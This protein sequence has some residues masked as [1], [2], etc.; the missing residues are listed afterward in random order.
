L[1]DA[2]GNDVVAFTN[3]TL[4]VDT[5]APTLSSSTPADNATAVAIANNLVLTF[6]E[7]VQA[8]TGNIVITNAS[9]ATDTR[10]I[11]VTDA[12]VAFSGSTVTIN[13][14]ADLKAGANYNV[15][16]AATAVKDAAGNAYAGITNSTAL[17]FSTVAP[18]VS[19]LTLTTGV[20]TI[21]GTAADETVDGS[22]F[23]SGGVFVNTLGNADNI[24]GGG[25]TNTLFAQFF[26]AAG[27]ATVT[28]ASVKNIQTISVENTTT[29]GA[30]DTL[31]LANGDATVKTVKTANNVLA[32]TV[33]NI[34]SVPTSF[35]VSTTAVAFTGTI[36][37]ALLAGTTDATALILNNVTGAAA[38]AVGTVAAGSGY[39]TINLTSNGT[40]ASSITLDDGFATS[41]A[42][43]NIAGANNLT[44]TLTPTTVTK[45]DA[46]SYTGALTF[47]AAGAN[48]QNMTVTGGTGNDIISVNGYTTADIINGGLGTDRLTLINAEAVAATTVNTNVSGFE[49]IGLSDGSTGTITVSNFG[50]TGFRFGANTAGVT[51]VN[52]AAGTSSLDLQTFTGAGGALTT[53]IAGTATTD[54]MNVTQGS[55]AAGNVFGAALT[56]T[57]AET[58]NLLSQGGPNSYT[59]L[60]LTDTAAN[61]SLILTGS[62]SF[63]VIGATRADTI[64]ASGM[65]GT[66]VLTLTGG[67]GTTATTITGTANDDVLNGSTLGDIINGG[68][69]ADT[70]SNV[71]TGNT[72]TAADVL[73]GGVGFDTLILRGDSA[74]AAVLPATA[75]GVVANISGFTVGTSATTTDILSLSST[76]TNYAGAATGF[77]AGIAAATAVAAGAT[78]FQ[79]VAQN[80]AV[81]ALIAGTDLIKLTT[82]V[83]S[84]ATVQATFNAAIG[85]GTVTGL[86]IGTEALVSYYDTT[87]SRMVLLVVDAAL[88]TNTIIETG[89]AVTL[90]GTIDMS[91]A[92]YASFGSNN[93]ALV[94]A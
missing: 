26:T 73:S 71:I 9:D 29:V 57:G 47:T 76:N 56:L 20:D 22:R 87:A 25:G 6:S 72:A 3:K 80:A 89:D 92:D 30:G 67:T 40:V 58:V 90:I 59:A 13:P 11:A 36:T 51:T 18:V 15:Q 43:V 34:Q 68:A 49:V 69:G 23:L 66:A 19:T 48:V 8:G 91:A 63:T 1:Q 55:T 53:V 60:T 88:T 39:E 27:G 12:Q 2:I 50:A 33:S 16:I 64:D 54:I 14:T 35:E 31:S 94:A 10:T 52:Y 28:P 44:L 74:Q 86:G 75:Y 17:N 81:A 21:N 62:Q 79:T 37:T 41:L 93:F 65:T 45:V 7:T 5:T 82:G 42:T 84:A 32:T 85:T 24:D 38:I 70:I 77:H 4:T 83:A 78:V 61:Q 46:S